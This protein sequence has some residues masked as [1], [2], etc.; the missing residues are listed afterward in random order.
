MLAGWGTLALGALGAGLAPGSPMG[1][2]AA[3][4]GL[5]GALTVLGGGFLR[6]RAA[7][8]AGLPR[9]AS[10]VAFPLGTALL[11]GGAGALLYP[12]F[13]PIDEFGIIAARYTYLPLMAVAA[14]FSGIALSI[15]GLDRRAPSEGVFALEKPGGTILDKLRELNPKH[16]FW[17][18]WKELDAEAAR[19]REKRGAEGRRG[20]D[21]RPLAI[22]CS[23]AVFLSLME[24]FGHAPTFRELVD[25]FDPIERVGPPDTIWGLIRVSHFRRLIEFAWWS[26]WRVLGFFLLPAFVIKV[27]LRERIADHGLQTRGFIDHAWIYALFFAIVLVTVIAVSYDEHFQTYYPFYDDASRSWFDFW[28]WELLYAAQFFSLEF[29]FRGFWLKA[30]KPAMGSHAIYAMVVPY[31]MIHFGKPFLETLAAILAGVV[32]GTLA[33]R[34]RSIWSGFLIHVSVAISMDV[35]A[36]LQTTGLPERWWPA[37]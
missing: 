29:F 36:L 33:L 9:K 30:A 21:W 22:F 10:P 37:L 6:D 18:T 14:I 4:V 11:V 2:L 16:F 31:C 17:D 27:I 12:C 15:D 23:G 7:R 26:G 1:A 5:V 20:Y 3:T 28:T 32:L 35:A 24:Y 34:T 19:M 13:L 8:A 25:H